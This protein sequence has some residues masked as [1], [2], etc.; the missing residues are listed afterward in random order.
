MTALPQTIPRL[1]PRGSLPTL[2]VGRYDTNRAI[3]DTCVRRGLYVSRPLI[4]AP[5][6]GGRAFS[7]RETGEGMRAAMIQAVF[8]PWLVRG[9]ANPGT[10]RGPAG[11]LA[12]LLIGTGFLLAGI[13]WR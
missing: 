11:S 6:V 4:S 7:Y 10:T 2:P 5:V 12:L 9:Y 1:Q 3:T 13:F 8:L